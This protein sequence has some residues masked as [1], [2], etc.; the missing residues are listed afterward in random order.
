MTSTPLAQQLPQR[1][2]SPRT[3]SQF[4]VL[5]GG[6]SSDRRSGRLE[7]KAILYDRLR[8]AN[9]SGILLLVRVRRLGTQR[10]ELAKPSRTDAISALRSQCRSAD[11][12]KCRA[13]QSVGESHGGDRDV[14]LVA[15]RLACI[16]QV[17]MG[18]RETVQE[19]GKKG[20]EKG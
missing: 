1:L 16:Y 8:V 15:P 11:Q 2:H 18:W 4:T 12:A 20:R 10:R 17:E 9:L 3:L 7:L 6:E 13:M 5:T 19:D 14:V